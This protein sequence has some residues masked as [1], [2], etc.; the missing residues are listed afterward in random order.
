MHKTV[1]ECLKTYL[2][3]RR[4][5][6]EE[7]VRLIRKYGAITPELPGTLYEDHQAI[8]MKIQGMEQALGLSREE[9]Q[10]PERLL[11]PLSSSVA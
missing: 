4:Q 8:F 11:S 6:E 1:Q 2:H 7:G 9:K 3:L 5:H 10:N